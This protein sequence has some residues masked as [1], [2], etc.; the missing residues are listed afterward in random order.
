MGTG[1][2]L[3]LRLANSRDGAGGG[4]LVKGQ[5]I[6]MKE[7]PCP[8]HLKASAICRRCACIG[9]LRPSHSHLLPYL[10]T[11]TLLATVHIAAGVRLYLA[12]ETSPM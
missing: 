3:P 1:L 7:H 11:P 12:A 8:F 4:G 5:L 9:S 10:Q 2:N 6:H